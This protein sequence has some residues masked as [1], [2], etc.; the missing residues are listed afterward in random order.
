[1]PLRLGLDR[2][3][4]PRTLSSSYIM[5]HAAMYNVR[6]WKGLKVNT[7]NLRRITSNRSTRFRV[8]VFLLKWPIVSLFLFINLLMY[9]GSDILS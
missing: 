9:L 3:P 6:Y 2:F 8:A 4:P 7:G 5:S 1:M